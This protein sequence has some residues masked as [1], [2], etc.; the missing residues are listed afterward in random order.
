MSSLRIC[1]SSS[2]RERENSNIR[3]DVVKIQSAVSDRGFWRS[4]KKPLS[5]PPFKRNVGLS[6]SL[7]SHQLRVVVPPRCKTSDRSWRSGHTKRLSKVS[8]KTLRWSWS[9]PVTRSFPAE[10]TYARH[11]SSHATPLPVNVKRCPDCL[12]YRC[13]S[14]PLIRFS[15]PPI[16]GSIRN[17]SN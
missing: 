12:L 10:R 3:L 6:P 13:H 5:Y 17:F 11:D 16:L 2:S 8:T 15:S 14:I 9:S 7:A 4:R 1:R